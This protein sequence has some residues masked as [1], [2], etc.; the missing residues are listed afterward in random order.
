[1]TR[2]TYPAPGR[3]PGRL[4]LAVSNPELEY[5]A[6]R[7]HYEERVFRNAHHYSIARFRPGAGSDITVVESFPLALWIAHLGDG[8][9][10]LLYVV[11]EDGENFCMSH[12]DYA[13][14]AEIYTQ[15]REEKQS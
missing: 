6:K 2:E 9:R 8:N 13:K 12:K 4:R 1:M 10:Y 15:M 7:E 5:G 3:A 14:F 11:T